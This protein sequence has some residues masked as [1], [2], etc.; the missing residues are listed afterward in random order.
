V[1]ARL[2]ALWPALRA[3]LLQ[4]LDVR[5]A[6]RTESLQTQLGERSAKE[7]ADITAVLREL[8]RSI[9][10]ELHEPEYKQM[11][12]SLWP[13]SERTQF[14]LNQAALRKR[15]EEIPGEIEAETARVQ[16]RYQA[17]QARLFPVA[18]TFLVPAGLQ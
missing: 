16:A 12:L 4:S 3:P 17:P 9:S 18:V 6:E 15:L 5:A 7:S 8:Q 13:Q 10:A 14:Q 2:L 1:Q 11:E